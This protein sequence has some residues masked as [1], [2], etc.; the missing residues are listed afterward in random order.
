[1]VVAA[2]LKG[3]GEGGGGVKQSD[4]QIGA[5]SKR[6]KKKKNKASFPNRGVHRAFMPYPVSFHFMLFQT[7]TLLRMTEWC[8]YL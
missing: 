4:L 7:V 1:M 6:A 2:E 8:T 3:E 5:R